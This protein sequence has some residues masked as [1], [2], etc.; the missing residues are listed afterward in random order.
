MTPR[1]SLRKLVGA[2]N[3]L[4][5]A[6]ESA[7]L[8]ACVRLLRERDGAIALLMPELTIANA[9]PG[10]R[11]L[12]AHVER[13]GLRIDASLTLQV[14]TLAGELR[15]VREAREALSRP[16]AAASGRSLGRA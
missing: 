4:L 14:A 9:L 8:P 12:L 16:I 3:S 13:A 10:E 2:T 15:E 11:E 7:D 5:A 6:A 1:A